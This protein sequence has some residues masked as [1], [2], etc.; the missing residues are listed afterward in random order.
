MNALGRK[1][2]ALIAA[3]G[4][5]TVAQYM[6]IALHDPK[7]GYYATRD[8]FGTDGDFITAP[9]VSQ[10]FGELIGL[11][12]VQAW[13]DR[14]RPD[15]F[16]LLELGPGRGTLMADMLRAARVRPQFLEAAQITLIESSTHLR[17][18]QK[19]TLEGFDI[20]WHDTL[21]AVPM[22]TPVF[23]VANEFLDALPIR[24]FIFAEGGWHERLVSAD[25]ERL[26]FGLSPDQAQIPGL[27]RM[28]EDGAVIEINLPALALAH[29][30]ATRIREDGGA[31][32][33][34]DYGHAESA[35]GNTF[36]AVKAHEYADPLE[37]PGD[38]DLTAHVDFGAF[39]RY[40]RASGAAAGTATPQGVFLH[41]LGIAARATRLKEVA[42]AEDI[43]AAVE[44]LTGED[45]MGTLF[46]AIGITQPGTPPIPGLDP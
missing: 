29:G 15:F 4:P 19:K 42:P 21:D 11:S 32:L 22:G 26:Y 12:L 5:I 18:V 43:D 28:A 2:A 20:A 6:T 33:F 16:H 38:A 27:P 10:M 1:I 24:Q 25:A 35:Y 8:P 34:I 30:L 44:R 7:H 45:E 23:L 31:A 41:R 3:E 40:A 39:A 46:K 9:E 13:E 17:G 36:Q 14:G 37:A